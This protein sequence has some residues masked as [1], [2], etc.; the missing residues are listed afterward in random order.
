ML[1]KSVF[2][3]DMDH[4]FFCYRMAAGNYKHAMKLEVDVENTGHTHLF[5]GTSDPEA[6][7]ET[8]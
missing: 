4:M 5:Q 3:N 6:T 1:V 2:L 7:F 8:V